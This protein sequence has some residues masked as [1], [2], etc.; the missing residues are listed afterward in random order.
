MPIYSIAHGH[1]DEHAESLRVGL[2]R[3]PKNFV[4]Q[5]CP[6]CNG[7]GSYVQRFNAG[8]GMG[9]FEIEAGCDWCGA[10]GLLQNDKPAPASVLIQVLNAR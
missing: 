8:C 9:S 7:R 3:L 10:T 2:E 1:E 4:A 6:S 5:I